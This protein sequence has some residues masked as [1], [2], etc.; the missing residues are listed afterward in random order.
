[1]TTTNDPIALH[2]ALMQVWVG[3]KSDLN[4]VLLDEG[5]R[6]LR[7]AIKSLQRALRV[8]GRRDVA[9]AAQAALA[10]LDGR[11]PELRAEL[12]PDA[13]AQL[14][15]ELRHAHAAMVA[16]VGQGLDEERARAHQH[17]NHHEQF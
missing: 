12:R 17:N 15:R 2:E 14:E 13:F 7:N 9:D 10:T 5:G 8:T 16:A 1:M 11:M 6:E 3:Q 4:E